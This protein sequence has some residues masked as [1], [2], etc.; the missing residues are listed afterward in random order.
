[1]KKHPSYGD[2][3]ER[4]R[5]SSTFLFVPGDRADRFASAWRSGA[6][7]VILD[8]EASV[9]PAN[10]AS[11]RTEVVR[12]LQA[13]CDGVTVLVRLNRLDTDEAARD[14]SDLAGLKGFGILCPGAEIGPLLRGL[15]DRARFSHPVVLLVETPA[16]IEQAHELARLPGVCRLAFGNMD[17]ITELGLGLSHWGQVYPASRLS[18]ASGMAGLPPPVAGVTANFRERAVLDADL[19]FERDIGFGAKMCIHPEQISIARSAF[20]PTAEECAWA[21]RV[22]SA[23]T[24]SHAVSLDGC[25]IDRPEI[26]RARRILGRN[27][28]GA[29]R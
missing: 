18:V 11:A 9:H 3:A 26:E 10:K 5:R 21:Y 15:L 13:G 14:W 20:T 12:R 17:Y 7:V 24:T 1:M 8:L 22:L 25:M 27:G 19:R 23:T 16:G 6:D 29:H 4:L 28:G 2:V